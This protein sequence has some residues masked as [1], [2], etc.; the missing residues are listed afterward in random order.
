MGLN[1]SV[2]WGVP[3]FL[4]ALIG[5]YT[6]H[7]L[8]MF[9]NDPKITW[10]DY[11]R[12]WIVRIFALLL[13]PVTIYLLSFKM[14]F[15]LLTKLGTES[16]TM[17]SVFISRLEGSGLEKNRIEVVDGAN[18]TLRATILNGGL[19]HSH[20]HKYP[21]GSK[22]QQVTSFREIDYNNNWIVD[23]LHP[24]SNESGIKDGTILNLKHSSSELLLTVHPGIDSPVQGKA[25]YEVSA[26]SASQNSQWKVRIYDDRQ[27]RNIQTVNA[28][29]TRIQL[30]SVH[31]ECLLAS[32]DRHLPA[33]GFKQL[34]VNCVKDIRSTDFDTLWNFEYN[35]HAQ[36]PPAPKG[37]IKPRFAWDVFRVHHA[38]WSTNVGLIP[39]P[40]KFNPLESVAMDWP[41]L[42]RGIR[43]CSWE[44]YDIKFFMFGNPI[45]WWFTSIT[46]ILFIF[47]GGWYIIRV[48]RQTMRWSSVEVSRFLFMSYAVFGGWCLH[49]IPFF[50]MTRVLYLHHYFPSL[51]FA[52]LLAP[53]SL[54]LTLSTF[55]QKAINYTF[56]VVALSC[57]ISFLLFSPLTYGFDYSPTKLYH[58]K[59][60]D[61]WLFV[62]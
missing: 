47:Q 58:L 20:D 6:I 33:W 25:A 9:L 23:V 53:Y 51:Y 48:R 18:V 19:L 34:E 60:L 52:C 37:H 45:I 26:S 46:V 3:L 12:H 22:E 49:F 13:L 62:I 40:D 44:D 17:D 28:I 61:S 39:D 36:L 55:S 4:V 7:Q 50:F 2:K 14:H 57:F 16:Y 59:W 38:M 43:M 5:L 21:F 11:I 15:G 56:I 27:A 8:W 1:C 54:E 41:L 35:Y 24:R 32:A 29:T 30:E 42:R 31:G 10:T